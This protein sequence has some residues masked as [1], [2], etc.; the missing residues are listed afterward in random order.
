MKKVS[1]FGFKQNSWYP[2][3]Y[4]ILEKHET[5][6]LRNMKYIHV[7]YVIQHSVSE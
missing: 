3:K 4:I 7:Q 1:S 5:E 6:V 2:K